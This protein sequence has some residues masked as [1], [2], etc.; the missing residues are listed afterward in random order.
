M[1]SSSRGDGG[2]AP[3]Y[4]C[5]RAETIRGGW[6][7]PA[8]TSTRS[9]LAGSSTCLRLLCSTGSARPGRACANGHRRLSIWRASAAVC[10]RYRW[11]AL[12]SRSRACGSSCHGRCVLERY[13]GEHAEAAVASLPVVEDIRVLEDRVRELNTGASALIKVPPRRSIRHRLYLEWSSSAR[14]S[15]PGGQRGGAEVAGLDRAAQAAVGRL[16]P[17]DHGTRQAVLLRRSARSL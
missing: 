5:G 10:R 2:T 1:A 13:R 7:T 4:P 8:A 9:T 11:C 12:G 15:Q 16:H 6:T 14:Y 17:V 3:G